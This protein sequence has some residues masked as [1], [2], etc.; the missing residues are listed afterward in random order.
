MTRL[1]S[2]NIDI[3]IFNDDVF[4]VSYPKSGRTWV[5][6]LIA[7][8]LSGNQCD[9]LNSY[10]IIPG[11]EYNP[12]QCVNVQ[13]PRFIQSH[14]T[15]TPEFKKVIFIVRDGRDVAVSYY[16]HLIK[17]KI[18]SKDTSFADYITMFNQGI[19]DNA[20]PWGNYIE[21][22]LKNAP[23]E[24]LLIKYED[25]KTDVVKELTK[26]I[27]FAGLPV[28]KKALLEAVDASSFEKMK[29]HEQS[30]KL[31]DELEKTDLSIPHVR[32]GKVGSYK[33]YF[34]D[35]MLK[36][37]NNYHG[38]A[39]AK[40]GYLSQDNLPNSQLK[41]MNSLIE[42]NNP[43]IDVDEL[44][45]KVREEVARRKPISL[46]QSEKITL[47][48]PMDSGKISS[49]E[50]LLNNA[51]YYSEVPVQFPD[52][53]KRF[54]FTIIKPLQN[55]ILKLYG[56]IFKK[57]RV[58]N[59]SITHALRESL[60][61]NQQLIGQVNALQS[62]V[63]ALQ[64]QLP[65]LSD[66]ITTTAIQVPTLRDQIMV[67]VSDL[68]ERAT[69][70]EA[71][72]PALSDRITAADGKM[73]QIS[74]RITETDGRISG[75]SDRLVATD[76]RYLKNDTYLKNDLAQQKRLISLFLEEARK[77]LPESFNREQVQ[78]LISEDQHL[79]DAFYVAFEERF[80]GSREDILSRLKV[81][82]PLLEEAQVGKEESPVL[83]IGCGRGEWLKLLKESGYIARGLDINR[84]M[85]DECKAK[86][87]DV[88]EEDV[89][90]HLQ[91]LPNDCLGAI[92]GFHIIEHLPFS[93]LIKLLSE[94]MRVLKPG[95]LAIF[96]TPNPQNILV[97]ANNFY[98]DPT[99]LSPLPSVL[100]QFLVEYVGFHAVEILNLNEYTESYKLDGSELAERFN[101]YFYGAQDYAVIGHK[102]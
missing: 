22:W 18:I 101:D 14:W 88:L 92:T 96:E 85:I 93:V 26:M 33:D 45:Q 87:F 75:I 59:S 98:I 25:L 43:E 81:Y 56:F 21:T 8:Y 55:F 24:F 42:T 47:I 58:V 51:D 10:S 64:A 70:T 95:G 97:G 72:L 6:F 7:N 60:V 20:S 36:E 38:A 37:F 15:F 28:N 17:F 49:I 94:T 71:Q 90:T 12:Q 76:E 52:K 50:G 9:F 77:R 91:S 66:R 73:N 102:L 44:M 82:L 31:Y 19:F 1:T 57:Q 41:N 16:F 89:I 63:N 74:D 4:L 61:L 80:R 11:I 53:F 54:P 78:T 3:E 69:A 30:G 29:S 86:G 83:D 68:F 40:L 46:L 27:E 48:N 65:T 39:L 79:L 13:R 2:K 100:S 34:D 23:E 99:H 35:E 5:R 62:Q 84:V 67:H 32:E